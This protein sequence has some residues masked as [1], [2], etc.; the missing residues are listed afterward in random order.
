MSEN[1][2]LRRIFRPKKVEIIG[3]WRKLHREE[4]RNLHTSVNITVTT[5][6]RKK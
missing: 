5:S 6:R 4:I 3:D 2:V 1:R